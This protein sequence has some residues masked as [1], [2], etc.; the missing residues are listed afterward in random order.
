MI[1]KR[2]WALVLLIATAALF[3]DVANRHGTR[4]IASA[5][6]A[7]PA[8]TLF[9]KRGSQVRYQVIR[10]PLP[11]KV[12]GK[13]AA[14][15]INHPASGDE[16][17]AKAPVLGHTSSANSSWSRQGLAHDA[18]L[19][20]MPL[21]AKRVRG[22]C[23]CATEIGDEHSE[24]ITALYVEREFLVPNPAAIEL[25]ELRANYR[26][27]IVVW[28]NGTEVARRNLPANMSAVGTARRPR[29]PEAEQF[30]IAVTPKLLISGE[31][32][33]RIEVRPSASRLSPS[34]DFE[35]VARRGPRLVRGP[36]VR[37]DDNGVHIAFDTDLP[38]K[39]LVDYYGEGENP[40][41]GRLESS[42]GE[43]AIHH[44]L[45]VPWAAHR[46]LHYQVIAGQAI[47]KTYIV[48][49]Q[50][51]AGEVVR[52]AV[53]GDMRGGHQVHG[54]II[55]ALT[56]EAPDFVVVT[57]DL[58]LR[59]SDSGDWQR[60]FAVAKDLLA[61]I[62][63]YPAAG[64]HDLGSSG[65]EARTMSELFVL[66][67]PPA[68]R[69]SWANWY[70]FDVASVHLVMLDSNAYKRREQLD[71]LKK[72]LADAKARGVRAIFAATHDGPY[73]RG[74]HRGN[75]YAARVYA[76]IL[77][78]HGIITLFSGHDHLY[79]RGERGGLRYIVSGGGGAPLYPVRCGKAGRPRCRV[80]D[81]MKHASSSFHYITVTVYKN[82]ARI[83][84]KRLSREALE[85]CLNYR[86]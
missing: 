43:L 76:P 31:N 67:H 70:S 66:P 84:P 77:A 38:S 14:L 26:D 78:K 29:G 9:I 32:T 61:Q 59:G 42:G 50:P 30:F 11:A 34:L 74:I 44:Q 23:R 72:D 46:P 63:Y 56:Q 83:C 55:K 54:K 53:Y 49:R 25:L 69:P 45:Y 39:A 4:S 75:R 27:G 21:A 48:N 82:H 20:S 68:K 71:W 2:H 35:L 19:G 13:I 58:V 73:S 18:A 28:I 47:S 3:T 86:Y 80:A 40:E 64:N 57:G 79:Q 7:Q 12:L 60:F 37:R 62:P 6:P 16:L 8:S 17:A 52:F 85:P 10:A 1:G 41:R 5:Q 22:S 81:G 65:D 33:L 51:K 24:R 15:T 36:T